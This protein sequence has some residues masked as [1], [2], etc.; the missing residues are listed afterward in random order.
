MFGAGTRT[1]ADCDTPVSFV[2]FSFYFFS[3]PLP[4]LVERQKARSF[5]P[6]PPSPLLLHFS[7]DYDFAYSRRTSLPSPPLFSP[8][9]PLL[10]IVPVGGKVAPGTRPRKIDFAREDCQR[11]IA[12]SV[13][14]RRRAR[15]SA[16]HFSRLSEEPGRILAQRRGG[17]SGKQGSSSIEGISSLDARNIFAEYILLAR[18]AFEVYRLASACVPHQRMHSVSSNSACINRELYISRRKKRSARVLRDRK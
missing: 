17:R 10:N 18:A 15:P 4:H 5:D 9:S 3:F 12:V 1:G 2:F 14:Q 11:P 8:L 7:A 16:N 13:C 6:R